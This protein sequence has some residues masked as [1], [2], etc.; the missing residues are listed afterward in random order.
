M[1]KSL[2]AII[3]S[4]ESSSLLIVREVEGTPWTIVLLCWSGL[5]NWLDGRWNCKRKRK[6]SEKLPAIPVYASTLV[7]IQNIQWR[8][9]L[10]N[11]VCTFGTWWEIYVNIEIVCWEEVFHIIGGGGE[12]GCTRCSL[13]AY[14]CV[15]VRKMVC[16]TKNMTVPAPGLNL[17]S[18]SQ[19]FSHSAAHLI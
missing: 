8:E 19:I 4:D 3:W 2:V 5:G 7:A 9:C 11:G 12:G 17:Y 13:H 1:T 6:N 16:L 10:M 18:F 15:C 14:M